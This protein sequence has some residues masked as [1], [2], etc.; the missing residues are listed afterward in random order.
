MSFRRVTL[1]AQATK[2]ATHPR[3]SASGDV[4]WTW[5]PSLPLNATS[6]GDVEGSE[7]FVGALVYWNLR[8]VYWNL[9]RRRHTARL[10]DLVRRRVAQ[11]IAPHQPA[12]SA[13]DWPA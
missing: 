5:S 4:T 6:P 13:D 1:R 9:R 8:L 7:I 10:R 3:V 2:W 12:P 11:R